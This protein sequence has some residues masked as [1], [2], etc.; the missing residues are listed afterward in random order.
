MSETE[1]KPRSRIS[2]AEPATPEPEKPKRDKPPRKRPVATSKGVATTQEIEDAFAEILALPAIP[3][4]ISGD[5]FCA[6]HFTVASRDFASKIAAQSEKNATLRKWCERLVD[7]ESLAVLLFAAM[8]Y[9]LPPMIHHNIVPGADGMR[10]IFGVPERETDTEM[11]E[12]LNGHSPE[13]VTATHMGTHGHP[14]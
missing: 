7:G 6:N 12:S 10:A 9:A 2:A 11:D 1:E 3:F 14:A 5:D 8:S 13:P 4:A